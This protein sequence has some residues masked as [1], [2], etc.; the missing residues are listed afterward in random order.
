MPMT[1]PKL[2]T[3]LTC[4]LLAGTSL[5]TAA[6]V[7]PQ[8]LLNPEPQNWLMNHRTYDGQRFSPLARIDKGN[9]KG[10]RLAYAVPI[11]GGAGDEYNESTPLAEDGFLYVVDSWGV[12]Y[13][14]DGRSGEVG[15]IVWRM[16]PKQE[17]QATNR[18][19]TF[20]GNLVISP[21]SYPARIIATDKE[22]GK[23]VWETNVV[24]GQNGVRMTGAPLAIKDKIIVGASGGDGGVRD[25][26]AA[27]DGASGRQL[28]LKYTIP[29]PGE[30]GSETWKDA[31][32]SWRTGGGAVWVTGTYDPASN[33]TFWGT[34]NPVPMMDPYARPGDNLYTNSIISYEPESGKMNWYFQYT[35]NDG[36]DYDEVGTHI[37][38][39][40]EVAG[41]PRK[42][43]THS[44]RN[45]FSYTMERANGA[46]VQAQPYMQ[47][48]NW[49]KGID[50]KTGKP[51]D[52]DPNKDVQ[53]YSGA[54][55][56][57]KDAPVKRLCPNRTGGNN[58]W[59]TS[60]SQKTKLMYIPAMTACEDVT[61]DREFAKNNK[62]Q[63]WFERTG[64]GY[65]APERYESNLTAVDPVTGEVKKNLRLKYPNYS[66]TLVTAGGLVFIA[67]MDG[68]VSAHDDTTLDEL[69]KINVGS[70]FAAPPMTFEVNGKQYVAIV[71]GPSGAAKSKLMNTP[72][73]RDQRHSTVL[74]VF[75][76]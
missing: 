52:Y 21:A 18:G 33:Q 9:V 15:R 69:W 7:T 3:A 36:W 14:I 47:G 37:L 10:L 32:N 68:T 46:I 31:N 12:L 71:S 65:K 53:V 63:G 17:R 34:G 56:P 66:G 25:W 41:Q 62:A 51:L 64:G 26:V 67:L 50:Q 61:N 60:Y 38:L 13:K 35:P 20:W 4:A 49:T 58:F 57:T 5:A 16:D 72:E 24:N 22:S 2:A 40:S 6:E 75:A 42:L 54:A 8:R 48:I 59:P 39:D 30:P 28:W 55:N 27:L 19:A 11:G 44:A 76:L 74:Y 23:V 1:S 45:G 29:A 43:I 73:L 70:G